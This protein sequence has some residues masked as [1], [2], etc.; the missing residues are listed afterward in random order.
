MNSKK[1]NLPIWEASL[2]EIEKSY[3]LISAR[4]ESSKSEQHEISNLINRKTELIKSYTTAI[5]EL[6]EHKYSIHLIDDIAELKALSLEL[7][8]INISISEYRL[9]LQQVSKNIEDQQNLQETL[10]D[11]IEQGLVLANE[12]KSSKC[13]LC[14]HLYADFETLAEKITNHS[15]LNNPLKNLLHQ[16]Q[17]I[18]DSINK[19][20]LLLND[21]NKILSKHYADRNHII[22]SELSLAQDRFNAVEASLVE[23]AYNLKSLLERQS[24]IT[25]SMQGKSLSEYALY[26]DSEISDY[27]SSIAQLSNDLSNLQS[28]LNSAR[29]ELEKQNAEVNLSK[30]SIDKLLSN[31]DYIA[32]R[33]YF[34]KSHPNCEPELSYVTESIKDIDCHLDE[35]A[36]KIQVCN[37]EIARL[38]GDLSKHSEEDLLRNIEALIAQQSMCEK[39][40][41]NYT[42]FFKDHFDCDV[43]GWV[44]SDISSRVDSMYN[45]RI[46]SQSNY[47]QTLAELLILEKNSE[48]ISEFLQTE[49]AKRELQIKEDELLFL[50]SCVRPSL[51]EEKNRA[52]E[53]LEGR[54]K[55][56]FFEELINKLYAKIDPH[57]QFKSVEF[58]SNLDSDNPRLDVFVKTEDS[59]CIIPNL[60]FSTA[61]INILSL[62]IFLASALKSSEYNCIFIDDPI[63]SMDSINVLS[64]IDLLRSI[65]INHNKQIII[66]THDE[67]FHNLL[68]KKMPTTLFKSKYLRLESFGKVV[69]DSF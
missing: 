11:F 24:S 50:S 46:E 10:Q 28:A 13:P 38:Q 17:Q 8:N 64:T 26:L 5:T 2:I 1:V 48:H 56:F 25:T 45:S 18:T 49:N 15:A 37:A 36:S 51:E 9:K 16:K 59:E 30:D 19:C 12:S 65:V 55:D 32:V 6:N 61:Q 44:Q 3:N 20:I 52:K 22:N 21:G 47:S 54:I 53:F 39:N 14:E 40:I 7:S 35:M 29:N 23:D 58:R 66:S 62:C 31:P 33:E 67:N 41:G 27:K 57:P 60:Y 42:L 4:I 68:R 43:S 34:N 69:A 63:Q